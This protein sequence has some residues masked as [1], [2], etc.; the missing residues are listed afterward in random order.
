MLVFGEI[1]LL[2]FEL[3]EIAVG[4]SGTK[5]LLPASLKKLRLNICPDAN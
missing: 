1:N 3:P 2:Y 4:D 5:A